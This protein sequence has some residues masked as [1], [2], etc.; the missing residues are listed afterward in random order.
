MAPKMK[1]IKKTINDAYA[2][3]LARYAHRENLTGIDIGYKNNSDSDALHVRLHVKEKIAKSALEASELFPDEIDGFPVT[4]IQGNYKAGVLQL[5]DI[6]NTDRTHRFAKL[7]PGIS[8]ANKNISA[9]TLGMIEKDKRS[10][11]PAILSNWHVLAGSTS[12]APGDK[13]VQPGPYD[14]GRD[15]QDTVAVLERMIL[16]KDGDAAIALLAN[17]RPFDPAIM[18]INVVPT[19]I[20]DPKIGDIVIKSGRTTRVTRGRVNGTGRYFINYPVGRVGVDGFIIVPINQGNTGDEEISM[21]GDSGSM[22]L[23]DGTTIAVG[24]HF[25]GETDPRP[26]EEHAIACFSTRVFSRLGIEPLQAAA[27]TENAGEENLLYQLS[28]QLGDASTDRIFDIMDP[29]DIHRFTALLQRSHPKL[30]NAVLSANELRGLNYAPEIGPLGAVA[31][32]FA[33]G[34]AARIIGKKMETTEQVS[35]EA[36]PV[37]VAAFIAG[38]VAGS[39]AVDGKL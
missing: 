37:V 4:V 15:P 11:R 20:S 16:D 21:G 2:E 5:S 31:L 24:L 17:T 13:I 35:A 39:R 9:G 28:T 12:A 38:A 30:S 23:K 27:N 6:E 29:L 26:S 3:A 19:G 14:G 32:G 25:A 1:S 10:G 33:A 18:D 22:W 36:L 8:V 7:Q 34:A